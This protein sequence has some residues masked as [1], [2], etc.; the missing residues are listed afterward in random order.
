MPSWSPWGILVVPVFLGPVGQSIPAP[1]GEPMTAVTRSPTTKVYPR[2]CGGTRISEERRTETGGLSPRLRGGTP[3]EAA[4]T[5]T[6][7]GLSPRL[8]G[9]RRGRWAGRPSAGSIPA[10][11]GEPSESRCSRQTF[12]VYPRACGGTNAPAAIPSRTPGLSPRLRGNR[13]S[14]RQSRSQH[15]SI[16]APAGE[17]GIQP[18]ALS[19]RRVYPRACGGTITAAMLGGDAVGLS[20]RLRGNQLQSLVGR[21]M[22]GSIPAPAGEPPAR[23]V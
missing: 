12:K 23:D 8:R 14:G 10:P 21:G 2:A 7:Y 18:F 6:I 15:R 1:A 11:A 4:Y 3:I 17:P 13:S 9:N 20:P 19:W 16:P 22:S 5:G